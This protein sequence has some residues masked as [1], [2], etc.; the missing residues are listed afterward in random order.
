[1][2][3]SSNPCPSATEAQMEQ[4][5]RMCAHALQNA[6]AT[7]VLNSTAAEQILECSDTI[8]ASLLKV[9][10]SLTVVD[11]F[12]K[13]EVP[14]DF[15]YHASDPGARSLVDQY[16]T[17]VRLFPQLRWYAANAAKQPLV[18]GAEGR[19]LVP[20]WQLIAP[21]YNEAC[22]IVV[23]V[24]ARVRG[25][26]FTNCLKG[27]LG[28]DRLRESK[29]KI[30]F[31]ERLRAEQGNHDILVV[32][33]QFGVRHRGRSVRRARFVMGENECG[34]G[35]FEVAIMLLLHADRLA[36]REE[37]WIDC[38]GDEYTLDVGGV[39]AS[40]PDFRC[41]CGQLKLEAKTSN[42]CSKGYGSVSA[43]FPLSQLA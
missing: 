41:S 39:H 13:E 40:A 20:R 12:A 24:L 37:L 19:Y 11:D 22:V 30:R 18:S 5:Q 35:L 7:L 2:T 8:Q 29:K 23:D 9:L 26:S 10:G 1:M 42:Y 16:A 4:I 33:A 3:T 34:L 27:A 25:E 14:S 31:F 6:L 32:Q 21:T 36:H 43:L 28:P 15:G 38:A 17:L